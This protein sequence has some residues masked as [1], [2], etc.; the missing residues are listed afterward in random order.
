MCSVVG[1]VL[2]EHKGRKG[3]AAPREMAQS[4]AEAKTW[5]APMSRAS[6]VGWLNISV[7]LVSGGKIEDKKQRLTKK[8]WSSF[9][10]ECPKSNVDR[11]V[12]TGIQE[13]VGGRE[14]NEGNGVSNVE[15]EI[16]STSASR[17]ASRGSSVA[18]EG[19]L[20]ATYVR[21]AL[22]TGWLGIYPSL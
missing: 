18:P 6:F 4:H 7:I 3:R 22:F 20:G 15:L 14:D 1:T 12:A 8:I 9:V 13:D 11:K 10:V 21:R 16:E 17:R 2:Q 19:H 5:V